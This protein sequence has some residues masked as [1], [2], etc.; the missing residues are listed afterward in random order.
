[1]VFIFTVFI[2]RPLYSR[3]LNVT[4]TLN[5]YNLTAEGQEGFTII[6]YKPG[7]EYV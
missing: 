4:N 7:D 1:M 6:Q 3:I 5:G 2:Y